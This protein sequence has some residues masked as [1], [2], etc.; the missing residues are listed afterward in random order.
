MTGVWFQALVLKLI[1]VWHRINKLILCLT[2]Q[3]NFY[4][5]WNALHIPQRQIF[6][7]D[8]H[9]QEHLKTSFW[10]LE[11]HVTIVWVFMNGSWLQVDRRVLAPSVMW[12]TFKALRAEIWKGLRYASTCIEYQKHNVFLVSMTTGLYHLNLGRD[13]FNLDV[14]RQKVCDT[15]KK[16]IWAST[17]TINVRMLCGGS[18]SISDCKRKGWLLLLRVVG[19]REEAGRHC[20]EQTE[21]AESLVVSFPPTFLCPQMTPHRVRALWS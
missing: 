6:S 17:I 5:D 19:A 20:W 13:T 18:N 12:F 3:S 8:I 4:D 7:K 14:S 1:L 21:E 15:F 16:I 9:W 11:F 2:W 10:Y